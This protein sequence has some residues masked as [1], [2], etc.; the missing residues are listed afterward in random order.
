MTSQTPAVLRLRALW[1]GVPAGGVS[2]A[3]CW[4]VLVLLAAPLRAGGTPPEEM[5]VKAV[6]VVNFIRLTQWGPIEGEPNATD[7]PVCALAKSEFAAAVR[8]AIAG[9]QAGQRSLSFHINP[10]PQPSECRVLLVDST[11]YKSARPALDAVKKAP[12]LTVG[13]GAGLLDLGGMF[14]LITDD[15]RIQFDASYEAVRISQLDVS[16]RLLHLAR[17]L[18]KPP[19]APR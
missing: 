3:L 13:N 14:E 8:Q 4:L 11:Q 1:P 19:G 17:K 15:G 16:A 12:V 9:K 5:A 7:L 6:A 10:D 2:V 18:R